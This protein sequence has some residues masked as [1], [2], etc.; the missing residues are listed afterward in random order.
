MRRVVVTINA[1][2]GGPPFEMK[3]ET[4]A[5]RRIGIYKV[6]V[7]KPKPQFHDYA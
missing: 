5:L 2:R 6:A 4:A 1:T 7:Y 3:S